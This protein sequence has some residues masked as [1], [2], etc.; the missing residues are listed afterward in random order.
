MEVIYD[1]LLQR[2]G[3]E[4][5]YRPLGNIGGHRFQSSGRNMVRTVIPCSRWATAGARFSM[6]CDAAY[7]TYFL[8]Y[9]CRDAEPDRAFGL[10]ESIRKLS[11]VPAL[12]VGLDDRGLLRPGFRGR[13]QRDRFRA[14]APARAARH[15]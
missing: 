3:H 5:L 9:W 13:Y 14:P 12:T 10:A 11:R 8:T 4:I 6:I 1:A 7:T 15:V 2:D